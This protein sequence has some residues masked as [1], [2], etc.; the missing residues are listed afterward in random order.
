MDHNLRAKKKHQKKVKRQRKKKFLSSNSLEMDVLEETILEHFLDLDT[1]DTLKL[2][3]LWN[4]HNPAGTFEEVPDEIWEV[5]TQ[6]FQELLMNKG[7]FRDTAGCFLMAVACSL[8]NS[9]E[10]L[11]GEEIREEV[12]HEVLCPRW[13]LLLQWYI[14]QK[15]IG[16]VTTLDKVRVFDSKY[17]LE[18]DMDMVED[19]ITQAYEFLTDDE[20]EVGA[21]F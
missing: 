10:Q 13:M 17:L 19:R 21:I 6:D 8:Q 7:E 14:A 15:G 4:M 5:W 3:A 2:T 16:P 12:V 1:N 11:Y 9:H 20:Q 18:M